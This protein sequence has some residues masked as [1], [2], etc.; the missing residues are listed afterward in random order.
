MFS[1]WNGHIPNIPGK[2]ATNR[3]QHQIGMAFP[4][5]VGWS[6]GPWAIGMIHRLD[7][8]T[9]DARSEEYQG[10]YQLNVFLVRKKNVFFLPSS[11]MC[12]QLFSKFRNSCTFWDWN[13]GREPLEP[14]NSG[15]RCHLIL[16]L[17]VPGF[18]QHWYLAPRKSYGETVKP[19]TS[20][21]PFWSPPE[22]LPSLFWPRLGRFNLDLWVS[23]AVCVCFFGWS[24]EALFCW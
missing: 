23:I 6:P 8:A 17:R 18:K 2:W 12:I 9:M 20:L 10:I 19:E 11:K 24:V 7:P 13:S 3:D 15:P 4:N 14:W 5:G 16:R 1:P 21:E 22:S